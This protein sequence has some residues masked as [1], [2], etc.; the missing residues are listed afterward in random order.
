MK[1][2]IT[3]SVLLLNCICLLLAQQNNQ[4]KAELTGNI[5]FDV[6]QPFGYVQFVELTI[7]DGGTGPYKAVMTGDTSLSTHTIYRPADLTKFVSKERLPVVV[8]GNGGCRN[9]SVEVRNLL[10]ELASHGFMVI[11]VGPVKNAIFEDWAPERNMSDP[12]SMT[13]AIDWAIEQNSIKE[14]HFYGKID[15]DKVAVMGQSCGGAMAMAVANDPRITTIIM[16][17]SGLFETPPSFLNP[18][19]QNQEGAPRM[20]MPI[21]P[22]SELKNLHGSIA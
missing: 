12:K 5:S 3:T 4:P 21:V 9:G 7:G 13:T 17:N 2:I 10:F 8:Y 6:S 11:A 18:D 19:N 14:S 15:V 22:K 1:K 16:W 20:S